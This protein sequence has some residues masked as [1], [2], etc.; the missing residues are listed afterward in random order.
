MKRLFLI[1][2]LSLMISILGCARGG[3]AT[4]G[5]AAQPIQSLDH[6][7]VDVGNMNSSA[8]PQ[9]GVN[10]AYPTN[11]AGHVDGKTLVVQ[12]QNGSEITAAR[13]EIADLSSPNATSLQEYLKVK[14]PKR[15]YKFVA[16][17]G[18]EGVRADLLDGPQTKESDIYLVSELKDF[19]HVQSH[20]SKTANGI[21]EGEEILLSVRI[22]YQ[23]LAYPV[24][25]PKTVQ[26]GEAYS[27]W[28]DCYTYVGACNPMGGV[29]VANDNNFHI[30]LSGYA[31]GRVVE[32]GPETQ[33]PF[34]SIKVDGDYL[35]AP[36]S[37]TLISDIYTTFTPSNPL[38]DQ[39]FISLKPGYVYLVRTINWPDEDLITKMRVENIARDS[40]VTITYQKLVYV[41]K[42]QLQ[43]QIDLIN[44]NTIKNEQSLAS[45]EVTLYNRSQ[46][47]NY[48]YAAFNFQYST[49]GN[50][51]ITNN[52]WDL[53]LESAGSGKLA[54]DVPLISGG[55]GGVVDLGVK[56]INAVT[57]AD[58]GDPNTHFSHLGVPVIKGH[59]YTV[60]N[61]E[62][63][64][65]Y[66]VVEVLDVDKDSR[67]A[68]LKFRRFKIA[69]PVHFQ[70]WIYQPLPQATKALTLKKSA[71]YGTD[72]FMAYLNQRGD[73]GPSNGSMVSLETQDGQPPHLSTDDRPYVGEIGFV[74]MGANVSF[75]KID[76]NDFAQLKGKFSNQTELHAGHVI[77]VFLEDYGYQTTLL[78]RVDNIAPDQSVSFT[79]RYLSRTKAPFVKD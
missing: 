7:G 52:S 77:A 21:V 22:K 66:G 42:E 65:S 43:K 1:L 48:F 57:L 27:F 61:F 25:P 69:S 54:F 29:G 60:F 13:S 68:Q 44:Q 49:S 9:T 24:A 73:V 8:V 55:L 35:V 40:S 19:I 38:K 63:I 37:N 72:L 67:W 71:V 16:M 20:L 50:M 17:N 36:L 51:F 78:M 18:L 79:T 26:L 33:I 62:D 45:G 15:A 70:K 12:N 75:S 31:H 74:D 28:G 46:W 53:M 5:P 14:F 58:F 2:S 76:S 6:G 39:D 47:N 11:W 30:G 59:A 34:A 4:L 3:D 56:D 23:G 41:R 10:I 32:L 64:A